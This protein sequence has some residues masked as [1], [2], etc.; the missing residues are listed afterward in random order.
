MRLYRP[1]R[2]LARYADFSGRSRRT[3]LGDLWLMLMVLS[4]LLIPAQAYLDFR[5]KP[6]SDV[7]LFAVTIC[8]VVALFVRRLHDQGRS[9]WWLVGGLPALA[10]IL[11]DQWRRLTLGWQAYGVDDPIAMEI[12]AG[13]SALYVMAMILAD[14]EEGPNRYGPDPR[15]SEPGEAR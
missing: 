4:L 13:L 10:T 14:G 9:G 1:W 12:A 3:E 5:T 11:M 7:A 2:V 6:I 15:H 8:P